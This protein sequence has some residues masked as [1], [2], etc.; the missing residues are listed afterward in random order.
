M[1][2]EIEDPSVSIVEESV[3]TADQPL[4]HILIKDKDKAKD[5]RQ[6]NHESEAEYQ[7]KLTVWA[8][9]ARTQTLARP[10]HQYVQ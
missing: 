6:E 9:R 4:Q 8:E 3:P 1:T 5:E 2:T 7:L 10:R